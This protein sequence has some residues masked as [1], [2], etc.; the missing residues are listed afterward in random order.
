MAQ[1]GGA[2]AAG[3]ESVR[4]AF[5]NNL[6]NSEEVGAGVSV[7]HRGTKVVDLW[8]G[9][10]DVEKTQPYAEDT[11]QLVFSTTKG[12]TAIAVAMCVERGLLSYD[13]K[14][15]TYWP[16]FAQ[17]GKADAT[18]AQL[19]SHQC[20]LYTVDG[21]IT[22]AEALDWSTIT[23]RLAATAPRW[24]IGSKHGY[25]ALTYGWLAGLACPNR[26]SREYRQ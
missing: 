10:F 23:A 13:E 21:D 20:G 18:V 24:D 3:W 1:V 26:K 25:H 15:S 7:Y 14:V 11:L 2:V 8:G 17:H 16:E 5:V 6:D 12:I 19:L 22:L 9:S 4:E